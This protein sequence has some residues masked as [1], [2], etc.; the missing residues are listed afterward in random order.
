MNS[1]CQNCAERRL[2]CHDY[3]HAYLEY[4]AERVRAREALQK[5]RYITSY[6]IEQSIRIEKRVRAKRSH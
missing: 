5:D 6:L 3:C 2:V 1:P 4:H